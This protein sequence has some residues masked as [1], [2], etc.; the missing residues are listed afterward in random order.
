MEYGGSC[1]GNRSRAESKLVKLKDRAP[2]HTKFENNIRLYRKFRY[3]LVL[4]NSQVDMYISEKI[5][6]AFLAGCIPIY[7]GTTKVFDLFNP[8]A[9]IFYD[10]DHTDLALEQIQ[11][12][13]QNQSAYQEMLDQPI[14]A[15]GTDTIE[16]YFSLRDDVGGGKLIRRIR[17]MLGYS[18]HPPMVV[19]QNS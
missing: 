6:L 17:E 8:N 7:Y 2:K 13:E 12:L 3:C 19:L 9:F 14:L 1:K 11:Y 4:E 5:A 15:N 18:P 10:I 16:R